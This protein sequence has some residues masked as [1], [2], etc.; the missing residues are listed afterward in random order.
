MARK[1]GTP[2]NGKY[3]EYEQRILNYLSYQY[4]QYLKKP[5]SRLHYSLSRVLEYAQKVNPDIIFI[6]KHVNVYRGCKIPR[7]SYNEVLKKMEKQKKIK[8]VPSILTEF[9]K[10]GLPPPIS[11]KRTL[12]ALTKK[13]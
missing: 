7:S 3:A 13:D 8:L 9:E 2:R 12:I 4:A 11:G 10:W 1:T 6:E 5:N